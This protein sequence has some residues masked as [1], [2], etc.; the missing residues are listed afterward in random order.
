MKFSVSEI[1]DLTRYRRTIYPKDYTDRAV[2]REI[3]ERILTNGTWAPTHGMTQ[4]WRFTV[5]TGE[6]RQRLSDFLGEV[7]RS[8]TPPEKFMPRK[9]ETITQRPLQSSVVIAIGL[10]RDPNG[11][12]NERD[13]LLAVACAVQNMHLTCAAYG[14]GAFW[15]TGGPMTG[16]AMR[17]HLG[18]GPNDQ[19]MGLFY[20]GYPAIE[21]PKGYRKPL[22]QLVKW[23]E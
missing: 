3:V 9:F 13:E 6:A 7:Y 10:V 11:K 18:L 14:L 20:I 4:P 16:P 19:A 22:D 23:E 8:T 21:W 17:D 1:S 2:H 15:A 5:Y 12:I